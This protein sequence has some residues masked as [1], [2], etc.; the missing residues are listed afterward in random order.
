MLFTDEEKCMIEILRKEK[1]YS[2]RRLLNEFPNKN[3]TRRGLDHLLQ[4]IDNTDSVARCPGSGR[5]Q[6][7]RTV[8]NVDAVAD[9]VQVWYAATSP[10]QRLFFSHQTEHTRGHSVC[11]SEQLL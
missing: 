11:Y 4:K 9:L 10:Q 1:Q 5:P 2:S 3:W 8:D 6:T 7:V